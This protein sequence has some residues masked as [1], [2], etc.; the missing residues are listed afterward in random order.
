MCHYF[1]GGGLKMVWALWMMRL[2]PL[3][4]LTH[5]V[6]GAKMMQSAI[7]GFSWSAKD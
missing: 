2:S 6:K 3:E 5:F 1:V 7:S 4:G